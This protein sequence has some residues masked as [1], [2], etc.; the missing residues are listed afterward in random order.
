MIVYLRLDQYQIVHCIWILKFWVFPDFI[1]E[2]NKCKLEESE[3][4][5]GGSEHFQGLK[6]QRSANGRIVLSKKLCDNVLNERS[7]R[8]VFLAPEDN[9]QWRLNRFKHRRF[10]VVFSC[11]LIF[12]FEEL[13]LMIIWWD[14]FLFFYCSKFWLTIY[15]K[16]RLINNHL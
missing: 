8:E 15:Y 12:Q 4:I 9:F 2:L 10:I 7:F 16:L 1:R 13:S 11:M 5:S 14:H 3:P 6:V